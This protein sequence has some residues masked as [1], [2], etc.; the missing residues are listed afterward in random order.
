MLWS[1]DVTSSENSQQIADFYTFSHIIHGLA[2]YAI[3]RLASRRKWSV[4]ACL[5][6]AVA[7]EAGWEILENTPFTIERY[8]AAT[9]SLNYYGDS[10]LNSV[11][12]MLF[13]VFGFFLARWLPVWV[14]VAL[15]I[16]M[17]VGVAL[18]IRDNLTLNIIMFLY[19]IEWIKA[20]QSGG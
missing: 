3:F 16:A 4:G 1:G 17:E 2:F 7:L 20:W 14:S 12:D 13:C 5:V 8:R 18:V 11:C 9:I 19:P 6:A 10:V 15:A